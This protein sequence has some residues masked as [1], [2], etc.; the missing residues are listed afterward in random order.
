M[1]RLSD[2]FTSEFRT[3]KKL[4]VTLCR[5][6]CDSAVK[7]RHATDSDQQQRALKTVRTVC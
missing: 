7:I 1:V 2:F 5:T 3:E 6:L 4:C